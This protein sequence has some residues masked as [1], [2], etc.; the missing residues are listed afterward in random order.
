V[1]GR[2]TY[3][4]LSPEL[5]PKLAIPGHAERDR[6]ID[7]AAAKT[8]VL[9]VLMQRAIR[10]EPGLSNQ[11]IRAISRTDRKQALRLMEELRREGHAVKPGE[12]RWA[13][14]IYVKSSNGG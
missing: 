1:I 13:R 12:R 4:T 14:W 8:R 7:W 11:E 9:S 3:W 2:G 5:H 10:G 6:R